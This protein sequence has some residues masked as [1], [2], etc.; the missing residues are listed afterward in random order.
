MADKHCKGCV[1]YCRLTGRSRYCTYY[2]TTGQR[3][4]CPPGKDCTV[5]VPKEKEETH[6]KQ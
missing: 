1:F 2:L 4:P 6:G 3:R 5:K